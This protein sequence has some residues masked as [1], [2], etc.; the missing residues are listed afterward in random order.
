MLRETD[1]YM[2]FKMAPSKEIL[3]KKLEIFWHTLEEHDAYHLFIIGHIW[4][5]SEDLIPLYSKGFW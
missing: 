1:Y 4:E 2:A 5:A 3:A